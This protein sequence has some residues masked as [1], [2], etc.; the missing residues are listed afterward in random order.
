MIARLA[1][2]PGTDEITIKRMKKRKLRLK[3][4]ITHLQSLQ[5]PDLDA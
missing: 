2:D 5:I 4:M 3:D 1:G